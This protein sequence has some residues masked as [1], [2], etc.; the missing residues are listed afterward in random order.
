MH[1]LLR[2]HG[3]FKVELAS[4]LLR[5]YFIAKFRG[6][7]LLCWAGGG[8]VILTQRVVPVPYPVHCVLPAVA[9]ATRRILRLQ[10]ARPGGFLYAT[11]GERAVC[12]GVLRLL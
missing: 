8:G 1:A 9:G 6:V 12:C 5:I 2:V 4:S 7:G 3:L 10:K 11:Q